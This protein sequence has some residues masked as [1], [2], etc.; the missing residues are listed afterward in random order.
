M[1]KHFIPI[2]I[3]LAALL[4]AGAFIYVKQGSASISIQEAG[5]KSIAFINQSIADQGVTASLIEVV[6][7]DE[8]FRIHLKIADTEYDSFM[9]KSGKFLFPSGFN[10]EEQTVEE[11]PLE[12]TSVEETTS[13]S[14]LDGFAQC[15]TEKGMKFYGSQTCGWCA[16]EK[17]LFG[18]SMQYVDYVECLDEETG[19]ATAA[20]AAEGIYVAGGLGVPT[21]Q[22]S[23]GEMSSGYKTLEELA[24]LSS[25]PLQ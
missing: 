18:D 14:D 22:L 25:C 9:T 3:I 11:T 6:D 13:Y 7:E 19:G 10:L 2:A 23:S 5:E 15:L 8:V 12:G 16:Q 21:W 17:E 24:E 20:C 4:I 1:Q